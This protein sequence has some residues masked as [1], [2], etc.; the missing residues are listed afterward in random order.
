[1]TIPTPDLTTTVTGAASSGS[2]GNVA[3]LLSRQAETNPDRQA[4]IAGDE[5][6]T[7]GRLAARAAAVAGDLKAV[8]IGRGDKVGLLF[9][10]GPDYVAAFFAVAALGATIVPINP[11]LKSEEIAHI[12][13]D[14]E[15]RLLIAHR[16]VLG[17][18]EQAV[19]GA[20]QVEAVLVAGGASPDSEQLSPGVPVRAL[21]DSWA[22]AFAPV[23]PSNWVEAVDAEQD[24]V[25]L[26]Y[27]SGTTGKPKGAML[28]HVN[29]TSAVG[30][31]LDALKLTRDDRFLAVLPLCHIYGLAVVMLG[32]VSRGGTVIVLEKFEVVPALKAI[33]R[34]RVTLLPAVPAMYQ[35]MVMELEKG[36]YD[37][38]S[39][40]LCISGASALA[41]ELIPQIERAFG[42]P[43]IEGYGMTETSCVSSLN[44]IDGL[45]KPGSVGVDFTNV[46]IAIIDEEGGILPPGPEHVGEIAVKGSNVMR[47]YYRNPEATA[48]CIIDGYFRTGDLGYK[49]EDGYLYIVGRKKELIIR[50]G[51]NIYPREVEE[52]ILRMPAVAEVAVIGVPDKF[53]GERVKAVVVVRAGESL[54]EEAVKAFCAARLAEYKVPRLVEFVAALPRNST[55]KVLKRL[56]S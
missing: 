17:E 8:G 4:V 11:L 15:A 54:D 44:P 5:T 6:V 34:E 7:Y 9:P 21:A 49:D 23:P 42:A 18:V 46:T 50:G 12:L 31:A 2:N 38:S 22:D 10:N 20:A 48:E 35:F 36:G 33:E 16:L 14:S 24:L 41:A 45:R 56:L 28:T 32:T 27:T 43:L 55:G 26:V 13:S 19:A 37:V 52:A 53:M 25:V 47:G 1:M 39:V 51:Q 3:W 30:S 29:L 40:R